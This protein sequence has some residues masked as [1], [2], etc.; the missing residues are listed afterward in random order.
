M[1]Q[2]TVR[3]RYERLPRHPSSAQ[4]V[5]EAAKRAVPNHS[6]VT[7]KAELSHFISRFSPEIARLA[8]SA[9]TVMRKRLPGAYELVYDNAYAL[10]VGFGPSERPSEALFSIVIYPRKVSL[11]FL[12]GAYLRDPDGVLAGSGR[13]VRHIRLESAAALE[14]GAVRALITAAI[15]DAGNSFDGTRRGEVI[16]R[17]ISKNQRPRRPPSAQS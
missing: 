5:S 10:V 6:R 7:A 9:L 14:K 4:G 16:V 1:L 15:E 8:R 17:A 3:Q 2:S 12:W 13:Q 11:C